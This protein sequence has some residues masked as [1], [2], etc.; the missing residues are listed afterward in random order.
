[1]EKNLKSGDKE[2][3]AEHAFLKRL[4]SFLEEGRP[5]KDFETTEKETVWLKNLNLLSAK[6]VL[7]II[8]CS[9]DKEILNYPPNAEPALE[10]DIKLEN[11][12]SELDY[13]AAKEMR[14]ALP[15]PKN[16]IDDLITACYT[17]LRLETFLTTGEKETRAWTIKKGSSAPEAAGKIHSDF[18]KGFIRADIIFWKDLLKT[19]SWTQAREKGLIRTE[20]KE[21]IVKDGDV[22]IFKI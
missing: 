13:E 12:L 15:H 2:A 19:G 16:T 20:G 18:E 22:I 21:Y 4:V 9:S 8:N 5:A 3:A 1:V 17:L 6:P 10:I 7:Y 11:E 14:N